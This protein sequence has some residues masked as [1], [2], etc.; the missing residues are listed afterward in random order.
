LLQ[1]SAT[2]RRNISTPLY[3][4]KG[5][6]GFSLAAD[7]MTLSRSAGDATSFFF[8]QHE[9]K[10]SMWN[11]YAGNAKLVNRRATVELPAYYSALSTV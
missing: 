3:G 2:E 4:S 10:A 5:F 7:E 9:P 8:I 11:V 6:H 1:S